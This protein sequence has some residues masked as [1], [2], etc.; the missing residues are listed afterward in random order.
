MIIIFDIASLVFF[1]VL[2]LIL[3]SC[4]LLFRWMVV[5]ILRCTL[6]FVQKFSFSFGIGCIVY[7]WWMYVCKQLL[8]NCCCW[9]LLTKQIR[10]VLPQILSSFRVTDRLEEDEEGIVQF[11]DAGSFT[12]TMTLKQ[13]VLNCNQHFVDHKNDKLWTSEFHFHLLFYYCYC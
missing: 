3:G 6:H 8:E 9:L 11:L 1:V 4:R 2:C 10:S 7:R 5:V 12:L 13:A